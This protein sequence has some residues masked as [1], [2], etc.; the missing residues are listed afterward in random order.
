MTMRDGVPGARSVPRWKA[1]QS[2]T[3]TALAAGEDVS[4]GMRGGL[5]TSRYMILKLPGPSPAVGIRVA[6][7]EPPT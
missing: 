1:L 5:A 2:V 4:K 6:M 3:G 7:P